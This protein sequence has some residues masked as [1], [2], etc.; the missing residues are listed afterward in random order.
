MLILT[1]LI[2]H[3][4]LPP[5]FLFIGTTIRLP[6]YSTFSRQ[7]DGECLKKIDEGNRSY[8]AKLGFIGRELRDDLLHIPRSDHRRFR[9][10][11][12]ESDALQCPR[13]KDE[14]LG[15]S[16]GS[17][18][19]I[20]CLWREKWREN[21]R[22]GL[23]F[24]QEWQWDCEGFFRKDRTRTYLLSLSRCQ[25]CVLW[26]FINKVLWKLGE[27]TRRITGIT[28]LRSDVSWKAKEAPLCKFS[29]AVHL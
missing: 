28:P 5:L 13:A 18:R 27:M 29:K 9:R 19:A 11:S 2:R 24:L 17:K 16:W 22:Q 21:G 15:F 3:F 8:F 7:Q 25:K 10:C 26:I 4:S 20:G 14:G 6:Y 1:W 12:S 23:D